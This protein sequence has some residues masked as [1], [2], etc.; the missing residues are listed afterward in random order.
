M[1]GTCRLSSA[2]KLYI[3]RSNA[4]NSANKFCRPR[5][6]RLDKGKRAAVQVN[7]KQILNSPE[8]RSR[9]G[10]EVR[11]PDTT[12]RTLRETRP[13]SRQAAAQEEHVVVKGSNKNGE[14]SS[15]TV[16]RMGNEAPLLGIQEFVDGE[17]HGDPPDGQ[18][19]AMEEDPHPVLPHGSAGSSP[20]DA[21]E[22]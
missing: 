9:V 14:V 8:I 11:D 20:E 12:E 19:V 16:T 22:L 1:N 5:D 21:M 6:P 13:H 3:K 4:K 10:R 7:E 17:H 18:D 15:A 2:F